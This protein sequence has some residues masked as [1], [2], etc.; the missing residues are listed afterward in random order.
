MVLCD[1]IGEQKAHKCVPR[2]TLRRGRRSCCLTNHS[3]EAAKNRSFLGIF[4]AKMLK[5]PN[6]S[7]ALSDLARRSQILL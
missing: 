6:F 5:S 4:L 3:K 7:L 1:T 2:T